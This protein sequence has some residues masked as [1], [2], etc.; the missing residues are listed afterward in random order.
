MARGLSLAT[1][2][3]NS[4]LGVQGV[5]GVDGS[6][7]LMLEMCLPDLPDRIVARSL[8]DCLERCTSVLKVVTI[9]K[10]TFMFKTEQSCC[11]SIVVLIKYY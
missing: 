4:Q 8:V 2:S 7:S 10:L 3:S 9:Y 1:R 6:E 5:P 11:G